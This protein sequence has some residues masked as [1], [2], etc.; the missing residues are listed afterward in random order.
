[1]KDLELLKIDEH[2]YGDV[3]KKYLSNSDI[4]TLLTDPRQFHVKKKDNANFANGRLFHQLMLEPDKAVNFPYV[5]ASTRNTKIYK[6]FLSENNLDFAMLEH[7]YNSIHSMTKFAMKNLFFFENIIGRD[8][9]NEVPGIQE[10]NGVLF[11]AK[12]DRIVSDIVIDIKTTSDIKKFK[13]SA[14]NYNY[15]SQ[16]YIYQTIFKKPMVFFVV[17]KNAKQDRRGNIYHDMGVYPVSEEFVASGEAKVATAVDIYNK[18]YGEKSQ[19]S[20]E[21]YL[22]NLTL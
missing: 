7:E 1:M 8:G 4:R 13:W 5:K 17:D 2:Y 15:D 16:A 22:I 6:E 9:E 21:D 14:Y 3:G 19:E 18:F 10:I 12:A 20:I 11:K